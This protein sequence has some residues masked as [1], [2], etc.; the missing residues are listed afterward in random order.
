MPD[1]PTINPYAFQPAFSHW[2]DATPDGDYVLNRD[3]V[4]DLGE[5]PRT[6]DGRDNPG[7][8]GDHWTLSEDGRLLAT[9]GL[10]WNGP[11]FIDDAACRMLGSL[12]HD[13]LC[14]EEAMA[15]GGCYSYWRRH[16]FFSDICAAQGEWKAMAF[17]SLWGLRAFNWAN[18]IKNRL[19]ARRK[20]HRRR[21]IS[22][23]R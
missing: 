12:V 11:T 19:T 6:Q 21:Q 3:L 9:K 20:A 2:F 22:S 1:I 17:V 18:V 10:R 23:N 5:R 13:I 7:C 15:G 4:I 16:R 14:T 8:C